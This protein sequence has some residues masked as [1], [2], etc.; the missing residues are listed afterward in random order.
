MVSPI[1]R[2]SNIVGL[3]WYLRTCMSMFP[4]DSDVAGLGTTHCAPL[5]KV[6]ASTQ[7]F[8][9]TPDLHLCIRFIHPI[10]RLDVLEGP[11][12]KIPYTEFLPK[13]YLRK[14][15]TTHHLA[16]CSSTKLRSHS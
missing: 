3:C 9:M 4:D 14:N 15:S 10:A 5:A 16:S 12:Y 7:M 1:L 11:K 8:A 6:I 2:V 13:T